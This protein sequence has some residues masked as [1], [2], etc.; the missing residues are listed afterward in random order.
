MCGIIDL[1]ET[2]WVWRSILLIL[3]VYLYNFIWHETSPDGESALFKLH[4]TE[5]VHLVETFYH[6]I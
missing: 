2:L 5:G 6:D 4:V 1:I 3:F